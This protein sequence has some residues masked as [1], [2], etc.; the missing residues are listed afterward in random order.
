MHFKHLLA[1]LLLL[2]TACGGGDA[3][4]PGD[5]GT[6]PDAS[7]NP[8]FTGLVINEVVAAGSPDWFEL[9]NRSSAAIDLEGAHFSDDA[10][11]PLRATFSAGQV[12]PAGGY[13]VVEVSDD[14][15]GFGLGKDEM[16]VVFDPDGG[17]IDRADW[18]EGDAPDGASWGRNPDGAGSFETMHTPTP[19]AANTPDPASTCGDDVVEGLELCDGADLAGA[20]C[21]G[22]GFASGDLACN[23]DCSGYDTAACEVGTQSVVINEVTSTGDDQIELVNLEAA[24]ID[25]EGWAVADSGYDP[26][27]TSTEDHRYQLPAG[28]RLAPGAYLVLEK[29]FDH[30][31]GLGKADSVTLY[32]ASGQVADL[33]TWPEDAAD[34]SYCRSPDGTGPF[35]T[36][37]AASF[38]AA[39]P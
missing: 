1:P 14:L 2:C 21:A 23:A 16:L 38:G 36:C 39:N 19:G 32:D 29:N 13:L 17:E 11:R 15:V 7:D 10:A 9:F 30:L 28:T 5:A 20:S 12:V 24:E 34:P 26:M 25:L 3:P 35:M 18:D 8:T 27:D 6:A 33:V 37:G 4:N 31:F 22:L